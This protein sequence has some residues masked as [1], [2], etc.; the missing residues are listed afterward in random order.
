MRPDSPARLDNW[1]E[2]LQASGCRLTNARRAVVAVMVSSQRAL[3]AHAVFHL[4]RQQS[5][6]LGLVTVYRTLDTLQALGLVQRVH[7]RQGCH[8]YVPACDAHQYLLVCQM[9]GQAD[10]VEAGALD[11]FI[12]RLAR[13]SGF[14]IREQWL[15]LSGICHHC[16]P[17]PA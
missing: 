4:A 15:Q 1:L 11:S 5:P 10:P 7:Q 13:R 12:A 14:Q 9:C 8:S 6:A 2:R 3:G 16:Q 17:Q